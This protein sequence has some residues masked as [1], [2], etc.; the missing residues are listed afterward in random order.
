MA[1]KMS[2]KA[3]LKAIKRSTHQN[4]QAYLFDQRKISYQ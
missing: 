4:K 3:I 2:D 1:K